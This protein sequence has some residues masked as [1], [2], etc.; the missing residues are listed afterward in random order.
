[1]KEFL[2]ILR[3]TRLGIGLVVVLIVAISAFPKEYADLIFLAVI[4]LAGM[5]FILKRT[6]Q[7]G[8][9]KFL[10]EEFAKYFTTKGESAKTVY[11]NINN[12]MTFAGRKFFMWTGIALIVLI[13]LFRSLVVIPAG[14][15]GVYHL[16]GKVADG[17][18]RSGLHL[19]NF[20]AS[21][22]KMSIQTEQYTMSVAKEEGLRQGDDSI[23]ALT[24]EGLTVGLDITVFYHLTEENASDVYKNLG[25]Y[26]GE[27]VIRPEIRGAIRDVVARYDLK[28]IYSEKRNEIV[29]AIQKKLEGSISPRGIVVESVLLRN[30]ALPANLAKSIQE[31]LQAE[32]E[33]Q[34]YDFVLEKEKKEAERKRIEAEGQRDSQK[35]INE[36][37]TE[38]YLN[39]LYIR[40]LKDRQ[41]TIYVPVNP[42]S[43]MPLFK[44]VQ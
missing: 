27:K 24:N 31:K 39:Y 14:M 44:G 32:Q 36:S 18:L 30:V 17:E 22:E 11:T 16:F 3:M 33:S 25:I 26:Y 8:V 42:E 15:T 1:M 12:N 21:V 6:H 9:A 40:E 23:D 41:G 4:F 7:N 10:S 5:G 20:L 37:L 38:K 19:I 34:R 35:I 13:I 29:D 28:T 43:G 2:D